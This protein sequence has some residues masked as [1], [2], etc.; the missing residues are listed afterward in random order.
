MEQA[1]GTLSNTTVR[2]A[3]LVIGLVIVA[4]AS[5]LVIL[6]QTH[7][8]AAHRELQGQLRSQAELLSHQLEFY[9][10]IVEDMARRIQVRDLLN[11]G[12]PKDAHDWAV[13]RRETLPNSIGLA[14]IN[15]DGDVLGDPTDLR[16]GSSC[17]HDLERLRLQ[18][19]IA[20]PPV[21][22]DIPRLSHFDLTER[23]IGD[24][25]SQI[26][27]VFASFTLDILQNSLESLVRPGQRLGIRDGQH[28]LLSEAGD[29]PSDQQRLYARAP[30]PKTDWHL[31]VHSVPEPEQF[32]AFQRLVVTTLVITLVLVSVAGWFGW[33]AARGPTR[34]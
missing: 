21:H 1:R 6:H 28:R 33:R 34:G 31:E 4:A 17:M 20:E 7:R 25:G 11:V 27:V 14:L 24:D 16:V 9:Q 3:L 15:M 19:D 29:P 12:S 18:E 32:A 10:Q 23:V 13:Q 26:G 22:L 5:M 8:A 30:I 2:L